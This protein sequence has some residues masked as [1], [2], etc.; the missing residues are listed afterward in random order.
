[1]SRALQLRQMLP[2]DMPAVLHIQRRA[3]GA[4]FVES[5]AVLQRKLEL[6]PRCCWVAEREGQM[7][8]YLYSH[9]W[10]GGS[11]PAVHQLL[12]ELPLQADVWFVHDLALDPAMQGRGLAS[13]LFQHACSQARLAGRTRSLLVALAGAEA[14]WRRQGYRRLD[15]RVH[16]TPEADLTTAYGAGACLM[17]C[18]LIETAPF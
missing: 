15:A 8:A 3:H 10:Q 14:F 17:Q 9:P 1:M 13:R 16:S 6:A 11:P 2:A 18:S 12:V 7:L 5:A 4:G